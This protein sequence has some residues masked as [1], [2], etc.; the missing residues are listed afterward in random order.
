MDAR[1]F[2]GLA[3]SVRFIFVRHGESEGNAA[4]ILQGR[5]EYSL[6]G[7]GRAQGAARARVIAS[8]LEGVPAEKRL[9]ASSPQSRAVETADLI[10][11]ETDFARRVIIGDLRELDLG[12][13]T[14]KTWDDI[15]DDPLFPDFR[16]RSWDAVPGSESSAL[17]YER[18]ERVWT[19]LRGEAAANG[20]A[21]VVSVSH[22]GMI[23]WLVKITLGCR[24]WF[25]LIPTANCCLY[26]FRAEPLG[27]DR[28]ACTAWEALDM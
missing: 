12:A 22:G 21:A 7:E 27:T 18:A 2:S 15:K 17:L 16:E 20:Y 24:T 1:F 14:G 23:Q 26:V 13:W 11:A 28:G 19:R 10:A 4:G 9:L 25:P 8:L 6:S 5:G 3:R